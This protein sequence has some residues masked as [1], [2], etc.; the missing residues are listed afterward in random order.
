MI[1]CFR[2]KRAS[3]NYSHYSFKNMSFGK[4]SVAIC[5]LISA[6][7]YISDD[8]LR[9][10]YLHL[11]YSLMEWNIGWAIINLLTPPLYVIKCPNPDL[12]SISIL[13]HSH[14]GS[15]SPRVPLKHNLGSNAIQSERLIRNIYTKHKHFK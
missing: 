3:N 9:I 7:Y 6:I 13:I 4:V 5:Y 11:Y 12:T 15:C 8:F 1:I 2:F 14:P 10:I